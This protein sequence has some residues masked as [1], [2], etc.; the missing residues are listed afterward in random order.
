M[1]CVKFT[2][3]QF[4]IWFNWTLTWTALS[5]KSQMTLPSMVTVPFDSAPA[6]GNKSYAYSMTIYDQACLDQAEPYSSN[7]SS[8]SS[9]NSTSIGRNDDHLSKWIQSQF[10]VYVGAVAVRISSL[11]LF[12]FCFD[13]FS[14]LN[15]STVIIHAKWSAR[16]SLWCYFPFSLKKVGL[17]V[18]HVCFLYYLYDF[19]F[20]YLFICLQIFEHGLC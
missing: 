16:H 14:F 19:H 18:V 15:S 9:N 11:S 10:V 8:N 13:A 20:C 17:F 2:I 3:V 6:S 4:T 12:Y 7:S 1:V 5:V